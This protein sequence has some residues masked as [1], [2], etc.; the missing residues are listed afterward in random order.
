MGILY[1]IIK[2]PGDYFLHNYAIEIVPAV[3][4]LTFKT[5]KF[6]FWPK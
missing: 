1:Q 2:D 6:I 3:F 4:V 5:I